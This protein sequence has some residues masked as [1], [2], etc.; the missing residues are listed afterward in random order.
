LWIGPYEVIDVLDR[1]NIVIIRGK[2]HVAVHKN[3][4]KIYHENKKLT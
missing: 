1:E 4:V 2:R 3:N